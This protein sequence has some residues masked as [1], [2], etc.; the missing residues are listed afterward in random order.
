VNPG[1]HHVLACWTLGFITLD[2]D[3]PVAGELTDP[4]L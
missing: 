1:F 4:A 3:V 2:V